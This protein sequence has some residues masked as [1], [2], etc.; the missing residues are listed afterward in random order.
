MNEAF[1]RRMMALALHVG[2]RGRTSPNPHVGAVITRA[3]EVIA[4]GY[5]H[6][7]GD[8]HAEVDALRKLGGRAEGATMYVTME[9]CNHHGRTGPCSE[10]VLAAGIR[11][12]V[13]GCEDRIPGHGGGAS[14]L[15]SAGVEIE[16]GVRRDEAE[17]LVADF[18]KRAL[19]GLPY[20]TL[21]AAITLDGHMATRTGDSKWI[22]GE[23]ARKHAHRLRDQ[24]DAIM[25][26]VGTVLA[27]DPELTVRHVRGR[28]PVR[29]V[30]DSAL[31]TPPDARMLSVESRA[32]TWIFHGAGS[33]PA[34]R[35]ALRA[36]GALLMEVPDGDRGLD[37]DE[38]L[39]ELA[40]RDVTRLLVEGGPTLHGTLLDR[41]LVDRVAIFMAPRILND[42]GALPL[43]IGR[44][45]EQ[46]SE[47]LTLR[48]RTVR[49]LGDD[50]LIE[51]AL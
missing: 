50:I 36:R 20:V 49:Q 44:A 18:Y 29:V 8:A 24:S 32:P 34:R 15:R 37:L 16:L 30:L 41:G 9:P 38:I 31:Q 27:D 39:R 13:I 6:R 12:V 45:R 33:D 5:H 11:R 14:V 19:L 46:M 40:R 22:T 26:G 1:D 21:K 48:G 7:A 3:G 35:D 17:T 2:A 10:A 42:A 51:G 47:A 43:S 23:R 28:D 25:V 4:T